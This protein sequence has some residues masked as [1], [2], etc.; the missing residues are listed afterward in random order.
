MFEEPDTVQRLMEGKLIRLNT[1]RFVFTNPADEV[2]IVAENYPQRDQWHLN[3]WSEN[4]DTLW[5]Y[6]H[7][8]DLSVDTLNLLVKMKDDTL[9]YL[10]IPVKLKEKGVRMRKKDAEKK[11]KRKNILKYTT[12]AKGSLSPV[13]TVH[14]TFNQ[15]IQTILPDSILLIAGNDSIYAPHFEP[16]DSLHLRYDLPVKLE[17]GMKYLLLFPDS[18][19][20][21]WNGYFNK[22]DHLKFSVKKTDAYGTLTINLHPEQNAHF[23]FQ[24]LN[25]KEEV[26]KQYPFTADTT[27]LLDYLAP[28][29]YLM[30]IIFD[31]NHNGKWDPGKYS[32]KLE[33]EGVTFNSKIINIRANW[34]IEESWSFDIQERKPPPGKGGKNKNHK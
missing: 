9:D 13:S 3:K 4:H 16:K 2:S 29:N 1:I 18:C 12:N 27:F 21:D 6:L 5:W 26:I 11:K 33:P 22:T 28:G 32:E 30:K 15:P 34:E 24:L 19:F 23:I 7:E 8:P 20:I 17:E 31:N 10:Y 14:I 25:Q